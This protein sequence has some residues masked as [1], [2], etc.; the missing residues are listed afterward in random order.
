[1]VYKWFTSGLQVVYKWTPMRLTS[2]YPL[3]IDELID[4]L[5]KEYI[6]VKTKKHK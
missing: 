5:L 3:H 1:M 6:F 4:E 2:Q